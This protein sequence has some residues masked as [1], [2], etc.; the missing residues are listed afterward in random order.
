MNTAE[1]KCREFLA[2]KGM[3]DRI[4][5][6]KNTDITAESTAIA[7]GVDVDRICKDAK[8]TDS[9]GTIPADQQPVISSITIREADAASGAESAVTSAEAPAVSSAASASS[10][11]AK[12]NA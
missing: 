4:I 11:V 9:N 10:L 7:L 2:G 8:P 12:S 6:F 5:D 1:A 3:E